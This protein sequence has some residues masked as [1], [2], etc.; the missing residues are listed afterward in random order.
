M[1][2]SYGFLDEDMD[3]AEMLF[4]SLSIPDND[5]FRSAKVGIAE[6]A[7]GFKLFE[8]G[9]GEIDWT[10]N[11][12]WLLCVTE[13]DGLRFEIARTVDGDEEMQAFFQDHEL[14]GGAAQLCLLLSE[15]DL[16]DVYRLRAV[17]ILQQRV[18]D[19]LQ[20]LYSTQDDI[21]AQPY[22]AGTEI[23]VQTYQDAMKLRRLEF[24]LLESAYESLENEVRLLIFSSP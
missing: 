18:F 6:C 16:R 17:T 4:L 5:A 19:Q 20:I 15:S 23:R 8:T 12:I 10:G 3:S 1:M 22:G 21:E 7:P 24:A 11:F 9:E 13:E 14:Q 2:F